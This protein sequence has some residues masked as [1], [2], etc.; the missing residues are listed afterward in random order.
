MKHSGCQP[1]LLW[2]WRPPVNL[3][4]IKSKIQLKYS[5]HYERE[6]KHFFTMLPPWKKN[7]FWNMEVLRFHGNIFVCSGKNS[8]P[9]KI[10]ESLN[11]AHER[12]R[13][14]LF[15]RNLPSGGGG[16]VTQ[17]ERVEEIMFLS[18]VRAFD[19]LPFSPSSPTSLSNIMIIIIGWS[20]T[21][22]FSTPLLRINCNRRRETFRPWN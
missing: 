17:T 4:A 12:K 8:F 7:D 14:S 5:C 1:L 15:H 2:L 11:G 3:C 20:R 19:P 13:E 22:A 16:G 10:G 21:S 9:W 6:A 18:R